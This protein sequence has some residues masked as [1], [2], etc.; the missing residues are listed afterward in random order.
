MRY[1]AAECISLGNV[2]LL[3]FRLPPENPKWFP[4][5]ARTKLAYDKAIEILEQLQAPPDY[6]KNIVSL[7]IAKG[8]EM[9]CPSHGHLQIIRSKISLANLS[10]GEEVPGKKLVVF[11]DACKTKGELRPGLLTHKAY[12]VIVDLEKGLQLPGRVTKDLRG[13]CVKVNDT[14]VG[15]SLQGSWNW[16]PFA[17][18]RYQ[19][20]E[21]DMASAFVNGY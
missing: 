20:A 17:S 1:V 11:F 14:R 6:Y 15:Y 13:K 12:D 7:W 5:P 16:S 4:I 10:Y 8:V 18:K 21:L 3:A 9:D 2:L 19:V